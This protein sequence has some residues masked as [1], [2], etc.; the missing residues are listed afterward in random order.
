M[1]AGTDA[2]AR[3]IASLSW[4]LNCNYTLRYVLI[5]SNW[6]FCMYICVNMELVL[7]VW[8][9]CVNM[10]LVSVVWDKCVNM[11]LVS[12][13]WDKCVN[14]ELVLVVRDK[15][16][17]VAAQSW[18]V[19]SYLLRPSIRR[20]LCHQLRIQLLYVWFFDKITFLYGWIQFF[21]PHRM[22]VV[23]YYYFIYF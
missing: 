1:S 7:V 19:R 4:S 18:M 11:E 3:C 2:L 20:R 17:N 16:T 13:V 23:V 8:D 12:V 22:V 14:M 21:I 6:H 5:P 15:C 9:K 10:E